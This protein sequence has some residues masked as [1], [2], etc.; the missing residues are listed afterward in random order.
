ML[1]IEVFVVVNAQGEYEVGTDEAQTW[2]RYNNDGCD[3]ANPARLIRVA[4][5][6]PTPKEVVIEATVPEEV[7]T[8]TATVQ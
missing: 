5:R 4:L 7:N 8:G 3:T 2:E 6:V 1:D